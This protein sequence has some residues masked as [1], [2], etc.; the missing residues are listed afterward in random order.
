M[1]K[2]VTWAAYGYTVLVIVASLAKIV[3]TFVPEDVTN[4]DKYGHGIAYFGFAIVWSLYFYVNNEGHSKKV[5]L[6]GVL[7]A[8][9][10]GIIFG[11]LM[12]VAQLTLT[13]Y[14]QFDLKDALANTTGIL[15]ALPL[16]YYFSKFFMLIKKRTI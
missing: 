3:M 10:F 7:K 1:R 14:R 15:I 11:I 4:G 13:N 6:N 2:L 12:E 8:A 16:L 9:V 5:F